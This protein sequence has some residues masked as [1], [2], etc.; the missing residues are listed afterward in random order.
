MTGTNFH[1][2]QPVRVIEVPIGTNC[3]PLI[4]NLFLFLLS[5]RY[6]GFSFL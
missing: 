2:P 3:A 5:K 1:S 4:A 6:Y